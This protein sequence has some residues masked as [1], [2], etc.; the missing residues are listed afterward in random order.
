[1]T[2]P[3]AL[4]QNVHARAERVV[5]VVGAVVAPRGARLAPLDAVEASLAVDH[6]FA[7]VA[8]V[9]PVGMGAVIGLP[10]VHGR[11]PRH[12]ASGPGIDRQGE[13]QSGGG[14]GNQINS[15][16]RHR[17]SPS[18]GGLLIDL[19]W[20]PSC[21]KVEGRLPPHRSSMIPIWAPVVSPVFPAGRITVSIVSAAPL[22][23]TVTQ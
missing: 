3:R 13:G 20:H 23:R 8:A 7:L 17:R 9:V 2:L 15:E 10:V 12:V 11:G 18:P 14:H 4:P 6:L 16:P 1:M 22:M 19:G 5:L 21:G